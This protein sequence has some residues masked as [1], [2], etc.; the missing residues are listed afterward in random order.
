MSARKEASRRR[1]LGHHPRAR[2]GHDRDRT[3]VRG[4]HRGRARRPAPVC[5]RGFP[6]RF[7]QGHRLSQDEKRRTEHLRSPNARARSN[8]SPLS[9]T[10]MPASSVRRSASCATRTTTA[11][12]PSTCWATWWSWTPWIRRST[13]GNKN[14]FNKTVVT[15][16]GEIVD[17]W[18][19]VT[20]GA[21]EAGGTGMLTKRREIKDLEHEV[22]E[23]RREIAGLEASSPV[24]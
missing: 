17:P 11:T 23:L 7:A 10:A 21:V 5:G 20:G 4:R 9:R 12:W 6:E 15:L 22:A 8:P 2:R 24:R 14:G 1:T 18:G 19:A 3:A 16:S 13:S